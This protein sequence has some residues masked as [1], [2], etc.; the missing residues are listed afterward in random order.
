MSK[1]DY[2]ENEVLKWCTGQSGAMG[3]GATPYIALFST[4]P[5]DAGGGVEITTNGQTRV[6]A[7]GKFGAPAGGAVSNSAAITFPAVTGSD[8]TVS[9]VALMDAAASGNMLRWQD[10]ANQTIVVGDLPHFPVGTINFT[11]D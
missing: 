3:A 4:S 1:T 11:E 7:A 5:T 2:L 8:I 6:S 10:I 9:A